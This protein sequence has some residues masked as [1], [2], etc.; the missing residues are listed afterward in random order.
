MNIIK[1]MSRKIKDKLNIK[2]NDLLLLMGIILVNKTNI[3]MNY[4][5]ALLQKSSLL[6]T[7]GGDYT[8]LYSNFLIFF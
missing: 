2:E 6:C 5:N 3:K 7:S 1:S 8:F 4:K